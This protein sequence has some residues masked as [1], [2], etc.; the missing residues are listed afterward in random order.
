MDQGYTMKTH[1]TDYETLER[2]TMKGPACQHN[3]QHGLMPE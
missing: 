3:G 2:K 1:L